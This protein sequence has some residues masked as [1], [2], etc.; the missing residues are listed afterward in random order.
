MRRHDLTDAYALMMDN[1]AA[2]QG[3][4]E[5]DMVVYNGGA[6][7]RFGSGGDVEIVAPGG[8]K[9]TAPDTETSGNFTVRGLFSFLAGIF[10]IG[11]GGT[12]TVTAD[13]EFI[14]VLENNGVNVGSTHV[15]GGV[16]VGGGSTT[17]PV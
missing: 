1:S 5:S 17:G 2:G 10:G 11:G 12:S 3:G 13:I 14:G 16:S 15:H 4:N 9:F 6:Y 8:L 7:I